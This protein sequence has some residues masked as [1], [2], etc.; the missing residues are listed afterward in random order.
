M[1]KNEIS[2]PVGALPGFYCLPAQWVQWPGGHLW[3]G[4]QES[5]ASFTAKEVL[6][7][8]QDHRSS[9]KPDLQWLVSP[10]EEK[11]PFIL[12]SILSSIILLLKPTFVQKDEN[13][14][15]PILTFVMVASDVCNGR[16]WRLLVVAS[17]IF[18]GH[19]WR[20]LW[21]LITNV[22]GWF[23]HLLWSLLTDVGGSFWRLLCSLLTF[24]MVTS[25]GY[26]RL[27]LTFA[28]VTSD[29]CWRSLLT[30]AMAAS[31]DCWWS[32]LTFLQCHINYSFPL[33]SISS[34][35]NSF[36]A[37]STYSYT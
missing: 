32:L 13:I 9:F 29:G 1:G 22:G 35:N 23:W 20:L 27:L 10:R 3:P 26:W 19:F 12:F 36:S 28:M 31:D 11:I 8:R 24:A 30:F 37:S 7:H 21:S 6:Y 14:P 17:D 33:M 15:I 16:F 4:H 18:Y 5:A 2:R 34:S 25:D